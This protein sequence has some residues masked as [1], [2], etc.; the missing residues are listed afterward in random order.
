M[1]KN[2]GKLGKLLN[3]YHEGRKPGTSC[4]KLYGDLCPDLEK[5]LLLKKTRKSD[6]GEDEGDHPE[7]H[8]DQIA[9][10]DVKKVPKE[11]KRKKYQPEEHGDKRFRKVQSTKRSWKEF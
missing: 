4:K 9:Q 10:T 11:S 3:A 7:F 8:P 1:G 5:K 6:V 2:I